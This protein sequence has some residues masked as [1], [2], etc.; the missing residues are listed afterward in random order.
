MVNIVR[1]AL[2]R[3]IAHC[4]RSNNGVHDFRFMFHILCVDHF[5]IV[6]DDRHLFHSLYILFTI[7]IFN[8]CVCMCIRIWCH[9]TSTYSVPY[10]VSF[11]RCYFRSTQRRFDAIQPKKNWNCVDCKCS[12]L[13]GAI[14]FFFILG[15]LPLLSCVFGSA[16]VYDSFQF[17][18][19][20]TKFSINGAHQRS[21]T[22]MEMPLNCSEK[23]VDLAL[24]Y[25]LFVGFRFYRCTL[26]SRD[27]SC[28]YVCV[29]QSR[30]IL[31]ST[32]SDMWC[33][34]RKTKHNSYDCRNRV[35]FRY[36][37]WRCFLCFFLSIL[38]RALGERWLLL[39][40]FCF[41]H[42]LLHRSHTKFT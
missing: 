22:K 36:F 35:S 38:H 3:H 27:N 21:C 30:H 16:I 23:W 19:I 4:V 28:T 1:L 13:F 5:A 8:L 14:V 41:F 12:T 10:V 25:S 31:H 32:G 11:G 20:L 9:F 42:L 15:S 34:K 17:P 37:Y 26:I 2:C 6:T 24:H 40:F 33:A 29:I 18:S 39:F 7:L